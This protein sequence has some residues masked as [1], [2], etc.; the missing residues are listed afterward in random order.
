M[1]RPS[2]VRKLVLLVAAAVTAGMAVAALLAIWQ[3][4]DRYADAR[5]QVM[6]A[7]AQVF[8]AAAASS[9]AD[10]KQTETL[11]AIRAIG[12]MP[13]VLFVQVKTPD[14]RGAGR[15]RWRVASGHRS[16]IK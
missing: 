15:T 16:L 3:E 6:Y 13:G 4:V 10:L 8:A 5:R 7:T 11:E 2:L 1:R 12:R 9:V 14:G